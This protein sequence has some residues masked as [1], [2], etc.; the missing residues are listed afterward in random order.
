MLF[1]FSSLLQVNKKSIGQVSLTQSGWL[2]R[3][4]KPGLINK[5]TLQTSKAQILKYSTQKSNAK[6]KILVKRK[7]QNFSCDPNRAESCHN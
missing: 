1:F 3:M 7:T 2:M 4:N 6:F 5:V